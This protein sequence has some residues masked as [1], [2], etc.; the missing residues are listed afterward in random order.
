MLTFGSVFSGIG[1]IDLGLQRAGWRC[2]WQ[3]ENDPFRCSILERHWPNVERHRDI[4]EVNF[5]KL[6]PVDLIAGGFPCQPVSGAGK[7]K[8]QMDKIGYGP[9]LPEPFASY[10]LLS[11]KIPN[12]LSIGGAVLSDLARCGY[13][14]EWQLLPAAALGAPHIRA[15]LWIVAYTRERR[16]R[17]QGHIEAGAPVVFGRRVI[18]T[19]RSEIG[20]SRHWCSESGLVRMVDGL[21]NGMGNE[22]A[23][24]GDAVIPQAAEFMGQIVAAASRQIMF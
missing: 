5:A 22:I 21:S 12:A 16:F 11:H 18:D 8:A 24:L 14:A 10:D 2:R 13:D 23:A 4:R 15:R 19:V 7:R 1:G 17:Q 20:K 6:A 3:V 9:N